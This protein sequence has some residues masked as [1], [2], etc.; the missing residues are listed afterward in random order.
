LTVM[1]LP[2]GVGVFRESQ[3][4]FGIRRTF[5]TPAFAFSGGDVKDRSRH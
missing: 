2:F 1:A 3:I 4:H 5:V